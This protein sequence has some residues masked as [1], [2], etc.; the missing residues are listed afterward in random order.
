MSRIT[1]Y[2]F[3]EVTKIEHYNNIPFTLVVWNMGC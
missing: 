1:I 2:I 3:A